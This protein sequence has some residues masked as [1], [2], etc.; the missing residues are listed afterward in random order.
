MQQLY[1]QDIVEEETILE[2]ASKESKK[3]VSKEMSRKIRER[4]APFIKWLKEAEQDSEEDDDKK[5]SG[6]DSS[7]TNQINKNGK[8]SS[9]NSGESSPIEEE[10]SPHEEEDAYEEDDDLVAFSHRVTGLK[11]QEATSVNGNGHLDGG[12][13]NNKENVDDDIDIDNI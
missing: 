10:E 4:V 9:N 5:K 11:L 7:S 8:R 2:W 12:N 3:Y 13:K 1:D 6:T